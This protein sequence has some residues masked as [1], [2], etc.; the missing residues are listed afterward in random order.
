MSGGVLLAMGDRLA[1]QDAD[2]GAGADLYVYLGAFDSPAAANADF[3]LPIATFAEEDGTFVNVQ[4]RVQGYEQGLQAPGSARP[5][6][7]VLGALAAALQG[8]AAPGS[9]AEAFARL[10]SGHA[11][12][13]GLTREDALAG[14]ALLEAAHA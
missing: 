10:A 5:A 4:G 11:A 14:G 8:S 6:W 2:F 1:D 9:A 13:A 12:F 7:L 3:L